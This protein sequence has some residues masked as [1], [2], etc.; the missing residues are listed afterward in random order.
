MT[1]ER[2][3]SALRDYYSALLRTHQDFVAPTQ[4]ELLNYVTRIP[5][6]L[7]LC[8]HWKQLDLPGTTKFSK[9]V[10]SLIVSLGRTNAP[11]EISRTSGVDGEVGR[12]VNT[13]F[14]KWVGT[15]TFG[16]F[17]ITSYV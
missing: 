16:G 13:T 11:V 1:V 3:K 2:L 9:G 15:A 8:R 12:D 10:S 17:P 7:Y 6:R 14:A 5:F 4:G